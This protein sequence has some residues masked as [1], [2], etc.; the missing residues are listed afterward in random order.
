M[1]A[2]KQQREAVGEWM[3]QVTLEQIQVYLDNLSSKG[4]SQGTLQTYRRSLM[5]FFNFLPE[6]QRVG[7]ETLFQWQ[8]HLLAQGYMP[9]TVNL[10]SSAVNGFLAYLGLWELQAL[11][12]AHAPG[13]KEQPELSRKEYLRLLAAAGAL[14]KRR[15]YMLV[16]AFA[17]TG[18]AVQELPLLTVEAVKSGV[19]HLPKRTL[20]LCPCLQTEL[21]HYARDTGVPAGPVFVTR[22]GKPL[23]RTTVTANIQQLSHQAQVAPEKCNPRC[24]RKLFFS[25]QED[26]QRDVARLVERAHHQLLEQEQLAVGW[27][28]AFSEER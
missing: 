23:N 5:H 10:F 26:F 28:E 14:G 25:T 21:L 20:R 27:E 15:A 17:A 19:V 6:G 18:V 7:R 3:A 11:P 13:E 9:R 8:E 24:L 2:V 22:R 4:C 16:K 12:R 1:Y